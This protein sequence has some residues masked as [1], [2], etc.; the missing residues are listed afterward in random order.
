MIFA[1]YEVGISYKPGIEA[2]TKLVW[3]QCSECM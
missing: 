1:W 2:G 3:D